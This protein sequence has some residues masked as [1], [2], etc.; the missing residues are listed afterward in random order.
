M[1]RKKSQAALIRM[2]EAGIRTVGELDTKRFFLLVRNVDAVGLPPHT[3]HASVLLRF[4]PDGAPFCCG[5]PFCHLRVLRIDGREELED[6]LRRA[7]NLQH[8][9]NVT[10]K[11]FAEYYDGIEFTAHLA[12]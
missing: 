11:V 12:E 4:L 7:M 3:L 6:Y 2:L 9:V 1:T 10:L 8:S 5:E